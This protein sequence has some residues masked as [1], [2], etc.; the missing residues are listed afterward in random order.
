MAHWFVVAPTFVLF[1][2]VA[3]LVDLKPHVDETFFFSSSDPKFQ[4][5]K[6]IDQTFPSDDQ[7]IVSVTSPDISSSHYLDRLE[8]IEKSWTQPLRIGLTFKRLLQVPKAKL[9]CS[10]IC[11]LPHDGL[12]RFISIT[13]R[14][15]SVVGPFGPGFLL[16][17]GE[18]STR[19]L[20]CTMAR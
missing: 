10:A 17:F 16:C 8:P 20:R 13:A 11:G 7:L 14:T 6:K 1:G 2:L 12:R 19:C 15:K 9:I 5:S 18:N 3:A 4:E